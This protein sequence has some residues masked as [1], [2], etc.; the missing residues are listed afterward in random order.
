MRTIW[1]REFEEPVLKERLLGCVDSRS[2][3]HFEDRERV[4][5]RDIE[6]WIERQR[7]KDRES[8]RK[9]EREG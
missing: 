7:Q 4:K 6:R 8:E 1:D 3:I 5:E 9:I 2:I